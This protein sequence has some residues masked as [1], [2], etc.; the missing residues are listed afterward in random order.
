MFGYRPSVHWKVIA[1][2]VIAILQPVRFLRAPIFYLIS[3]FPFYNRDFNQVEIKILQ[4]HS[5]A[6]LLSMENKINCI[7]TTAN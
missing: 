4:L 5:S 6:F 7:E 1:L 2:C 3:H